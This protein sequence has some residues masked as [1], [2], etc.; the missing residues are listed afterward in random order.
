[1]SE[2]DQSSS[3][4]LIV[5]SANMSSKCW[6]VRPGARY[7]FINQ[8]IEDGFVATGHLDTAELTQIDLDAL[9]GAE[10]DEIYSICDRLKSDL[11]INTRAQVISFVKEMVEGDVVFTLSGGYVYP[12]VIGSGAYIEH[13]PL[14]KSERFQVRR[15]VVW[16]DKIGRDKIP[17]TLSKSFN[18]YQAVFS[19]GDNSKEIHHWLNSFFVSKGSYYTSLRVEQVGA[20]SHHALKNLSEIMDRLQ[21]LSVLIGQ[22]ST[23]DFHD[24]EYQPYTLE[25]LLESME[26]F[27]GNGLLALSQQ[28]LTM[29]PGD[30]WY[31]LPSTCKRTGVA[32]LVGMAMLFEQTIAFA[33]PALHKICEEVTPIVAQNMGAIKKDVN[34]ESVRKNLW[35][36]VPRQNKKFVEE[37]KPVVEEFPEDGDPRYSVR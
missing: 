28:Q 31:E 14:S 19:L 18:A 9:A 20:L 34:L 10:G 17:V 25:K 15:K 22:E 8:F 4:G 11:S 30:I 16:G 27:D 24:G 2:V 3:Q 12:G 29:S 26:V 6:V 36:K 13:L 33:D 32:F 35:V 23:A 1:M 21:V 37:A 5:K 7:R